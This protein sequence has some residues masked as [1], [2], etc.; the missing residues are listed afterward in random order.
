MDEVTIEK[1]NLKDVNGNIVAVIEKPLKV[2]INPDLIILDSSGFK[3]V[4]RLELDATTEMIISATD[5]VKTALGIQ[6]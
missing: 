3:R 1:I 5:E 6:T 2:T 4:R